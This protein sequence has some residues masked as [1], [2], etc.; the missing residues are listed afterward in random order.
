M[1]EPISDAEIERAFIG[2]N[3]GDNSNHRKR[4]AM[5][6]LKKLTGYWS[7]STITRIMR[8]L[9]LVD[10]H[11]NVTKRG[12]DFCLGQFYRDGRDSA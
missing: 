5:A 8:D 4:L 2:T 10:V 3:F 6:V 7:G 12:K 11:D 1:N 9:R